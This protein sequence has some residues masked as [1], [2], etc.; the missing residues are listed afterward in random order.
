MSE[1]NSVD[2][3]VVGGGPTSLLLTSLLVRSGHKILTVEQYDKFEQGLYGR[4]CMLYAGSLEILDL[5]GVYER[6]A[7]IGFI[8]KNAVTYKDGVQSSSRGW[9][10]VQSVLAESDTM[11]KYSFSLRQKHLEDALRE[12]IE[13][14]DSSAVKAPVKLL[15]YRTIDSPE[16]PI[17]ATVED[18]GDIREIHC[19]YLVGADGGRSAVR[20]LGNFR[21]PGTASPH[22]W[23]R[24]DAVVKTDMPLSQTHAISI[25]SKF[26]GNVLW[27]PTDNGRVRIGFV[28]DQEPG[29]QVT[30]DLIMDAAKQAV[31]P[32]TLEFVKLDWWTIYKI[33]QHI[34]DTF[35]QGRVFLA[36]DAAHTHSS[37]AAQGMNT[38]FHDA[39]NLGWKLAGV[40]NGLYSEDILDTYSSERRQSA[41]RM[42]NLDKDI[43]ALISGKI[44]DHFNAPRDAD[45]NDYLAKLHSTNAMFTTG[46]GISYETN[47][48]NR[49]ST[50]HVA[51]VEIGHRAPDGP[52]F[53]L[54]RVIA[55]PLRKL[56]GYTGRFWVVIFSGKLERTETAMR[57]SPRCS[58]NYRA[59]RAEIDSPQSFFNMRPTSWNFL[60]I[61][62]GRG[63]LPASDLIGSAPLGKTVCDFSGEVFATYGVDENMGAVVVVRPDGIVS[64]KATL[65]GAGGQQLGE[66][67]TSL[68][69]HGIRPSPRPGAH[70]PPS[71]G[72]ELDVEGKEPVQVLV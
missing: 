16:Y 6:V 18:Q 13:E 30:E 45:P 61:I 63:S 46:L 43:A 69:G 15:N 54:G 38:G 53:R 25:E 47:W 28:Y 24:L 2:V 29:T 51:T 64:L 27:T 8:V 39:L 14:T 26:Y 48:V 67:L 11:F 72:Y 10:F 31:H 44:P 60:T 62:S 41:E 19:K 40:L 12:V 3:L 59:L 66:Y 42:M 32:F 58:T 37:G 33:G 55:Q 49:P 65:D 70:E 4:A 36:G 23:V 7:D 56:V 9:S 34:A 68:A 52:L 35:R 50:S 21:F 22:H 71:R 57:L 5:V 20:K 17:V 1:P